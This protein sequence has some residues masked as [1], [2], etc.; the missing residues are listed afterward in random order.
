MRNTNEVERDSAV[1]DCGGR[2][3]VVSP[4]PAT[5]VQKNNRIPGAIT[6]ENNGRLPLMNMYDDTSG[7]GFLNDRRSTM[8]SSM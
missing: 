2:A 8:Q 1:G 3:I 6:P 5:V 4:G 7:A